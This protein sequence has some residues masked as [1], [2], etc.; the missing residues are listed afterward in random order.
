VVL[1]DLLSGYLGEL[2]SG[3]ARVTFTPTGGTSLTGEDADQYTAEYEV[4]IP[5]HGVPWFPIQWSGPYKP[6]PKPTPKD[7]DLGTG[8][9]NRDSTEEPNL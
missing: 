1:Q 2:S 7:E 8:T 4:E 5:P 9:Q 6:K 3:I